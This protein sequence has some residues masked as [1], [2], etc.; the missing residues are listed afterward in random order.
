L[1]QSKNLENIGKQLDTLGSL[2]VMSAN[3]L[4]L[5]RSDKK[6]FYDVLRTFDSSLWNGRKRMLDMGCGYGAFSELV[7]N[8]L[9]FGEIHGIDIDEER[10]KVAAQRGLTVSDCNLETDRFPYPPNSFGF[11][12]SFGAFDHLGSLDNV[13]SEARRVL[14]PEGCLAISTTN[15]GSWVNRIALLLGYQPRN[16]EISKKGLFGVHSLYRDSYSCASPMGR[17]SVHTLRALEE[18]LKFHGFEPIKRWGV[19]LVPSPDKGPAIFLRTLD[20][21]FSKRASWAVRYLLLSRKIK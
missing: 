3:A 1:I 9:G 14:E 20:K 16:L 8:A 12:I 7:A 13:V 15:L 2:D 11:I 21:M 4:Q 5:F 10:G 17:V 6:F 18:Y 19:G